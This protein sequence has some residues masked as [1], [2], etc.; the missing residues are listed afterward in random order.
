MINKPIF[1][2]AGWSGAGK[3]MLL[4]KLLA[5]CV[6]DGLTVAVIKQTHH[7][8]DLDQPGK[9]SWR[10]RQAGATQVIVASERRWALLNEAPAPPLDELVGKLSPCDLVW[11]EGYKHAPIA[12]LEVHRAANG[13]DWLYPH[14]P[15]IVALACDSATDSALPQFDL[16]DAA[17][18]YLFIRHYTGV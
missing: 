10:H 3:T 18:I 16:N 15:A 7:A 4:E 12:K 2:L 11:V 8:V 6:A 5:H 14:D 9:D 17:A 1:G 13:K